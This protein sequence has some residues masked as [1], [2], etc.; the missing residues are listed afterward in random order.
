MVSP[1]GALLRPYLHPENVDHNYMIAERSLCFILCHAFRHPLTENTD[2]N[3]VF[4][5]R[6]PG[7]GRKGIW[8]LWISHL[9]AQ[10]QSS[11]VFGLRGGS[12]SPRFYF[13]VIGWRWR[14][15]AIK[16][17]PTL[18]WVHQMLRWIYTPVLPV[19]FNLLR[20]TL[21]FFLVW[22]DTCRSPRFVAH[23][24]SLW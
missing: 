3:F 23:L 16:R 15:I 13:S 19:V 1:V 18:E 11:C 12:L 4:V 22:S 20:M 21:Y 8:L 24:Y 2:V 7:L 14:R 6:S 5:V 9:L 17:I 10:A